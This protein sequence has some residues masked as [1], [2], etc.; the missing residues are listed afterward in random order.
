VLGK[1]VDIVLARSKMP[2]PMTPG[3]VQYT[4]LFEGK[5]YAIRGGACNGKALPNNGKNL[6]TYVLAKDGDGSKSGWQ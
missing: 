1:V 3:Q 6:N 4:A 5:N 2:D